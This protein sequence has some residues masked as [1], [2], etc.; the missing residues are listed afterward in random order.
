MLISFPEPRFEAL[1]IQAALVKMGGKYRFITLE[2]FS[3]TA[4]SSS[5]TVMGKLTAD[6]GHMNL[7]SKNYDDLNSFQNDPDKLLSL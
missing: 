2:N 6:N 4:T 5:K 7:G 1:S 3:D